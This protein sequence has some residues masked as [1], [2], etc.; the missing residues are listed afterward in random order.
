MAASDY[1]QFVDN[2]L[3]WLD[4]LRTHA[5]HAT[6][7]QCPSCRTKWNY[8]ERRRRFD[9]VVF[10]AQGMRAG[11]A[12]CSCQCSRNA[13]QTLFRRLDS[14]AADI[15]RRMHRRGGISLIDE[16]F[17]LSTME[18]LRSRSGKY[19][20]DEAVGRAIFF[21]GLDLEARIALLLEPEIIEI[22]ARCL[23][24]HHGEKILK[25]AGIS[26]TGATLQTP[27]NWREH[28]RRQTQMLPRTLG[29]KK[30][31]PPVSKSKPTVNKKSGGSPLH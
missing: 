29:L 24:A 23:V 2:E 28:L 21:N 12:A 5:S 20:P 16:N 3:C 14:R 11:A 30:L 15:V 19:S 31:K 8:N 4:G 22:A 6:Q 17:T 7:R 27:G 18:K 9:L 26:L 13:A 1:R 25:A 10:Y